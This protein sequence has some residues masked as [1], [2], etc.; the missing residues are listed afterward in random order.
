MQFDRP[1]LSLSFASVITNSGFLL[2]QISAL[3]SS[4]VSRPLLLILIFFFNFFY[5][6][7]I[8]PFLP[9]LFPIGRAPSYLPIIIGVRF[10]GPAITTEFVLATGPWLF[11]KLL[12]PKQSFLVLSRRLGSRALQRISSVA[13]YP[14]NSCYGRFK[15]FV[16]LRSLDQWLRYP[17][18]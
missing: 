14:T 5:I 16:L 13:T 9:F 18:H 15:L 17:Y 6:A 11:T 4:I 12:I 3:A 7:E 8:G 10:S 2:P 1:I